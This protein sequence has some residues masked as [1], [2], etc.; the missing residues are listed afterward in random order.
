[1]SELMNNWF[2]IEDVMENIPVL[3][4]LYEQQCMP[5]QTTDPYLSSFLP[6]ISD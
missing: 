1:M 5:R 4:Q 3:L 2:Q 6:K